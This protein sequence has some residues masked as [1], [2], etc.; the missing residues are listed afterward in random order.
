M[1]KTH[2]SIHA[3]FVALKSSFAVLVKTV[4]GGKSWVVI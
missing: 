3:L 4:D 2:L 1:D